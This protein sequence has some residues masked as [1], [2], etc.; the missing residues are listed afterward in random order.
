MK[1]MREKSKCYQ[2]SQKVGGN[3]FFVK[4][5]L[6]VGLASINALRLS[7]SFVP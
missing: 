5:L 1:N 6:K 3:C 2:E 7:N 4:G